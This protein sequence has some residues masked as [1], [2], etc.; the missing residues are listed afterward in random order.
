VLGED[1][2]AGWGRMPFGPFLI[3]AILELLLFG[4]EIRELATTYR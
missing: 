1:A 4:N 2:D 3:M